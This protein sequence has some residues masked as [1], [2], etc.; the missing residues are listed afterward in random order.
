MLKQEGYFFI[1]L[2]AMCSKKWATPFVFSS[3]Y[4][5]PASIHKP[6][7]Q[8]GREERSVWRVGG[9]GRREEREGRREER[10]GR[11]K[12]REGRRREKGGGRREK[13]GG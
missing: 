11:R 4:R 9:E 7:W 13:G 8:E 6:T 10:E 3:S 1:T 2:N 12:E 5:V